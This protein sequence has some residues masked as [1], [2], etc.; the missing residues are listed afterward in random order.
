MGLTL[1]E[2]DKRGAVHNKDY[3][4][5]QFTLKMNFSVWGGGNY[6]IYKP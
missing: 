4:D 3:N 6:V 2:A 1:I 5:I